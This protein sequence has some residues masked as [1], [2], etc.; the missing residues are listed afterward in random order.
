MVRKPNERYF[1][2]LQID[3]GSKYTAI[4]VHDITGKIVIDSKVVSRLYVGDLKLCHE[5]P[6]ASVVYHNI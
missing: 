5:H 1:Q 3:F 4:Q 2:I 6:L